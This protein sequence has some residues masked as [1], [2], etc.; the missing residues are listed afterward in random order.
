MARMEKW[1][2]GLGQTVDLASVASVQVEFNSITSLTRRILRLL[3]GSDATDHGFA[4]KLSRQV[5]LNHKPH[6]T[7]FRVLR[8]Y[9]PA[10]KRIF[11]E[12]SSVAIMSPMAQMWGI[13]GA[14]LVALTIG[15]GNACQVRREEMGSAL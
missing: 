9:S 4:V 3:I 7:L 12:D 8:S 5:H 2:R 14:E 1:R 13:D 11:T 15:I 10:W 6:L